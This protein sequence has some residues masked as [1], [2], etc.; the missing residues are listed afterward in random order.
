MGSCG[1]L[2]ASILRETPSIPSLSECCLLLESAV[3]LDT[4]NLTYSFKTTPQDIEAVSWLEAHRR[5]PPSITQNELFDTLS[6]AKFDPLFWE[7]LSA[8]NALALD[9]KTI[10]MQSLR[11]GWSAVLL[12]IGALQRK[13][14]LK[15]EMDEL[16]RKERLDLMLVSS[17]VKE[18][19]VRRELLMTCPEG[20]DEELKRKIEKVE[21]TLEMKYNC[22]RNA[23][24]P[25]L[26]ETTKE[27]SRKS[28]AKEIAQLLK[29]DCLFKH[30]WKLFLSYS[31]RCR[32]SFRR[33]RARQ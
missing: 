2:I 10:P 30:D 24:N 14:G 26:L 16:I 5:S 28:L 20:C 32:S 1:T 17:T 33:L 18:K 27:F 29:Y 8:R 3:L 23:Q 6:T 25:H 31:S 11:V 15:E 22:S 4:L 21:Q 7:S 9:Y 13:Q 19:V 12:P